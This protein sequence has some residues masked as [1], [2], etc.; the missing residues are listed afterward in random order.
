MQ[1]SLNVKMEKVLKDT[2]LAENSKEA[3]EMY[4]ALWGDDDRYQFD[5]KKNTY[6]FIDYENEDDE[7]MS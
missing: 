4:F 2:E 1:A 3:Y 7:E 6:V 5:K